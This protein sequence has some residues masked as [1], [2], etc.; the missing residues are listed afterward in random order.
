MSRDICDLRIAA[1]YQLKSTSGV[2]HFLGPK[3]Q[4]R[5]IQ[6]KPKFFLQNLVTVKGFGVLGSILYV[7]V[8]NLVLRSITEILI[9]IIILRLKSK[10]MNLN[11]FY[12]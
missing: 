4:V 10:I 12:F 6:K 1:S 2:L 5:P 9:K 7:Q 11:M 3:S 8:L